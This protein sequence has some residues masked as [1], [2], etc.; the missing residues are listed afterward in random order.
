MPATMLSQK[1]TYHTSTRT[2]LMPQMLKGGLERMM[3]TI[4][5]VCD[6]ND[7]GKIMA[8]MLGKRPMGTALHIWLTIVCQTRTANWGL[9]TVKMYV[10]ARYVA[11]SCILTLALHCTPEEL[12]TD[13]ELCFLLSL[14]TPYQS[15]SQ[16]CVWV[17]VS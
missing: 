1:Y 13:D 17:Q 7:G 5:I 16:R 2:W 11:G 14:A 3:M 9:C 8:C 6:A 10:R 12:E 15:L 4:R